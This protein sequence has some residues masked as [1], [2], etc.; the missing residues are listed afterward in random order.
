[1]KL[2]NLAAMTAL[3]YGLIDEVGELIFGNAIFSQKYSF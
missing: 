3:I 2:S 1:M